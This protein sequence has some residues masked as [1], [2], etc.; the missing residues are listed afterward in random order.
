MLKKIIT[1]EIP[2]PTLGAPYS[3]KLVAVGRVIWV[4]SRGK[5]P[6]AMYLNPMTG[7]IY[8]I[9]PIPGTETFTI[10]AVNPTDASDYV[11]AS[12]SLTV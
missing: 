10:R 4:V 8:G 6:A 9:P 5:L 11:E 3:T 1:T 2:N 12:F 7:E